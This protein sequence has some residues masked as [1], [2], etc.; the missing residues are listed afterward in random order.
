MPFRFNL[1][2][3]ERCRTPQIGVETVSD[4]VTPF[5]TPCLREGCLGAAHSMF[6]RV[7][8]VE[9][10]RPSDEELEAHIATFPQRYRERRGLNPTPERIEAAANEAREHVKNGGL[11]SRPWKGAK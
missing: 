4:G 11:I 10:Y 7:P 3:C 5:M 8:V 1:W 9:W 6:Y 2:V